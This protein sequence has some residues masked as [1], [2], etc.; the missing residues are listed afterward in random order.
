MKKKTL[1]LHADFY[2]IFTKPRRLEL[3]CLLR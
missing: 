2:K 3:L 1:K